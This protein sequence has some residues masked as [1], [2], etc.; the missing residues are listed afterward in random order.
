M[1][2]LFIGVVMAF[3]NGL[4]GLYEKYSKPAL[5]KLKS[6]LNKPAPSAEPVAD[7]DATPVR[8]AA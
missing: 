4:A 1:G 6:M 7:M 8:E 2:L 3:P 5:I